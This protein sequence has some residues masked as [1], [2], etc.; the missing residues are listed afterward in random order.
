M[1]KQ[2]S[3]PDHRY[4]PGNGCDCESCLKA[5]RIATQRADIRYGAPGIEPANSETLY[6]TGYDE[7]G[8]TD[9]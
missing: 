4:E 3:K 8:P 1:E 5:Q 2:V 9:E 6:I 7:W